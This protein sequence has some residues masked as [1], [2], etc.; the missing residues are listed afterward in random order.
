M[1]ERDLIQRARAGE[2]DAFG[3]L[4]R[5]HQARLRAYAARFLDRPDD[6]YDLVQDAFLD[7]LRNLDSFDPSGDL[8]A[9]LRGICKNRILNFFR[10]RQ[11]RRNADLALVDAAL[12][13]RVAALPDAPDD[14]VLRVDALKD[15][16]GEL[17]ESHRRVLE[18]RYH[19]GH[20]V[21]RIASAFNRSAS[22]ISMI[23]L[24]VR[25]TLTKCVQRKLRTAES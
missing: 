1:E 18:L 5:L 13:E 25:S 4:V 3:Q 8:A 17:Q 9:W 14:A 22:S 23:L 24:R 6:V 21:S 7:A 15:C 19:A 16:M 12:A 2:K 20:S 11:V 10:S